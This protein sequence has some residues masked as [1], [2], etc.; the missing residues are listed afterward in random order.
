MFVML[1]VAVVFVLVV[2]AMA[3]A[4]FGGSALVVHFVLAATDGQQFFVQNPGFGL[5]VLAPI[6]LASV[7]EIGNFFLCHFHEFA[8]LLEGIF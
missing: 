4:L 7:L 8:V 1:V 6:Q 3:A 5:V 2:V